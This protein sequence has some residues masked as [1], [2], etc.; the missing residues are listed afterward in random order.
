MSQRTVHVAERI[1]SLMVEAEE[2]GTVFQVALAEL[3]TGEQ[4]R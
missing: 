2:E 1:T 4:L 3:N